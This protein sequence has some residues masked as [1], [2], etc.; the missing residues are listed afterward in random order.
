MLNSIYIKLLSYIIQIVDL[1]NKKKII[2]FF[3]NNFESDKLNIIDIGAHKGETIN[4]FYNNFNINKIIAFEA[5]KLI[6][7]KLKQNINK[8]KTNKIEIIN[9][10]IGEKEETK[11]LSIFNE[12]SSSTFS[13]INKKS[14]YYQ[15]K[16]KFLS[17]FKRKDEDLNYY[18]ETKIFPLSSFKNFNDLNKIDI[19]KIDTEGYE[20]KVLKGINPLD[21]RKIR[22]IYFEHHYDL[23]L[24]KN[25]KYFDIMN[26]LNEHNFYVSLKIKMN[27]RKTFEYIYENK[28]FES[29]S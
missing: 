26:F 15:R 21:F 28:K 25:Y 22:Y 19:L 12:T 17:F 2:S 11:N 7:E 9:S 20:L 5:N 10:G 18:A 27:F 1:K 14:K 3:K 29:K 16:A 23:M 8:K 13:D 4:I 6:F 24:K